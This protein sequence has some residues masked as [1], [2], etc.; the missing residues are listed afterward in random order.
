AGRLRSASHCRLSRST[1]CG[2]SATREAI[3]LGSARAGT[4]GSALFESTGPGVYSVS[5]ITGRAR[6]SE[7]RIR[8]RRR[9]RLHPAQVV[10]SGFAGAIAV[11]T[12]LLMLPIA[13]VGPGGASF[14]QA[15]FTATS[16]VCVTGLTV[17]DTATF[18]TPLGQ[19]II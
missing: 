8:A 10:A 12:I 15:L 13:K 5:V 17:V 9:F 6:P 14:V 7:A 11:G 1:C 2:P 18:W 3:R 4:S 19:L 16:A